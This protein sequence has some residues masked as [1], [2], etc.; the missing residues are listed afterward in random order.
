MTAVE[1]SP[2]DYESCQWFF[3]TNAYASDD[4]RAFE[5][6]NEHTCIW[7]GYH[8]QEDI[9]AGATINQV[10]V[11]CEGYVSVAGD[12][13]VKV[14]VSWDGGS[15]WGPWRALDFGI[16]ESTK[17][18]DV[19]SDTTWTRDKLS[20]TNFRVQLYYQTAG[21]EGC[22]PKRMYF[23]VWEKNTYGLK[24]VD[25][26]RQGDLVLCACREQGLH[27]EPVLELKAHYGKWRLLDIWSG[28]LDVPYGD[29]VFR[30]RHHGQVTDTHPVLVQ[31]KGVWRPLPAME[32]RVGD[33]MRHI[34]HKQ[35]KG[36]A[37]IPLEDHF[38]TSVPIDRIDE[39][40][41]TG[42][43]YDVVVPAPCRNFFIATYMTDEERQK[44]MSLV[45]AG[46]LDLDAFVDPPPEM[47]KWTGYVDHL[48]V[49]VDYTEALAKTARRMLLKVGL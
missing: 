48:P 29:K 38:L 20:D 11:K 40:F 28:Q 9:P 19:T 3:P 18:K 23:A 12:E 22:F 47:G 31:R 1:Q 46:F 26:L 41:L 36:T 24:R 25:K 27:F 17:Q 16:N 7:K 30:W 15:S 5:V 32:L 34:D 39:R 6:S 35:I 8:F 42:V 43:V 13:D 45:D 4:N 37:P 33:L 14:R 2:S 10:V 21:G 44:I 49:L